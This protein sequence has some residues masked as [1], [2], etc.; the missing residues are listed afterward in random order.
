MPVWWEPVDDD[1]W[2][3]L[4]RCGQCGTYRDVVAANDVVKAF[5]R[6][7]DHGAAEI[8]IAVGRM[9]RERMAAETETFV[10]ALRRDLIDA[11][12]FR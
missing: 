2:R 8:R 11:G 3:M 12:D 6:D 7:L 10:A 1:R 5:E 4:L 9:D